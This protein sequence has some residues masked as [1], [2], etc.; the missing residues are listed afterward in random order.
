M[1][2]IFMCAAVLS[3]AV[4]ATTAQANL[5]D[6]GG[7]ENSTPNSQTSGSAWTVTT[8]DPNDGTAGGIFS[9]GG[10]AVKEGTRG[11]WFQS[12][13][14]SNDPNGTPPRDLDLAQDV[15]APQNGDYDLFFWVAREANVA[16]TSL[17]ASLSSS[18]TGGSTSVDL[19]TATY[20]DNLNFADGD[21]TRFQLSLTG[22]TAGD[23]LTTSVALVGG[24][25]AGINPQSLM[26]DNFNLQVPE[27]ASIAL[28]GMGLMGVSVLRRK[29]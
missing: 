3:L 7:F 18:G 1:K 10:W 19:L 6:D 29:R 14:G 27:P 4:F 13:Q 21:G 20:N 28:I 15:V 8:N 26:V 24:V 2:K 11:F 5:L 23:T 22:V 17:T 25:D 12:F 9:D 16:A